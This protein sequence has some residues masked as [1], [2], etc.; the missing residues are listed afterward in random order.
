MPAARSALIQTMV[1]RVSLDDVI[2]Y[3]NDALAAYLHTP[4]RSLIGASLEDVLRLCDGEVASCFAR[5]ESGRTSNRLV[6]DERGRVFEAKLYSNGGGL[7][8]VLDEIGTAG[9]VASE[10]REASGTPLDSLTEDELRTIR[11]PEQ[12]YLSVT[13]TRLQGLAQF[14]GRLDPMEVKLMVDSFVEEAAEAV[15]D[16]GCTVGETDPRHG[17]GDLRSSA[18]LRRPSFASHSGCLRANPEGVSVACRPQP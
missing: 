15:R 12:R 6:T 5:P 2:V 13:Y 3:V 9:P 16:T 8:I 10:L 4:K 1:A 14:A 17:S 7:D 11:H 18:L